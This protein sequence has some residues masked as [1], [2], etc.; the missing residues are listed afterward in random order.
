MINNELQLFARE[1]FARDGIALYLRSRAPGAEGMHFGRVLFERVDEGPVYIEPTVVLDRTAAQ[2]L[3]DDLWACGIRP[4][5]GAG[6]AGAMAATQ[7]HVK[8]LQGVLY[9]LLTLVEREPKA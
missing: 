9:R 6:T 8:D 5:D 1:E 7:A 3:M 2:V 4:T